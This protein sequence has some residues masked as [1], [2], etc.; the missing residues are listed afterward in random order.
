M[1]KREL[2]NLSKGAF[3]FNPIRQALPG[4]AA[5]TTTAK[6]RRVAVN[7]CQDEATSLLG[8]ETEASLTREAEMKRSR[9]DCVGD[10]NAIKVSVGVGDRGRA[11]EHQQRID[12]SLRPIPI[13][14]TA[15]QIFDFP[16]DIYWY[17]SA[18]RRALRGVR[19]HLK[20]VW[21]FY[22][23]YSADTK[24][25]LPSYFTPT[26]LR[27]AEF[28]AELRAFAACGVQC[29]TWT[30]DAHADAPEAE[31][32]AEAEGA[33]HTW[34]GLCISATATKPLRLLLRDY[35]AACRANKAYFA[36]ELEH[37][38]QVRDMR[39]LPLKS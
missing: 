21:K 16:D 2:A 25:V 32:E 1:S 28:E 5:T 19:A 33:L 38:F 13:R 36:L 24:C 20:A 7:T 31:A 14:I 4:P 17:S 9:G 10:A 22:P 35:A 29:K 11:T 6:R 8:A 18:S 34:H 15:R 27:H 3:D 26:T 39:L 23:A 12:D 30:S 37:V